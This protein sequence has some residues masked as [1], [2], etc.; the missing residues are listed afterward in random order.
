MFWIGQMLV[1]GLDPDGQLLPQRSWL[2]GVRFV[3]LACLLV[4]IGGLAQM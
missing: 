4:V 3:T 1:G 2:L